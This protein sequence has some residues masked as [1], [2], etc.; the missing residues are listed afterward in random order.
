MMR[1][2][3]QLLVA[4]R[5]ERASQRREHRQLVVRPLDRGQRGA[6]G[7]DFLALVKRSA[8]DEHVRDAARLERLDVGARD[9][10]LPAHETA[11]QKADVL[12]RDLDRPPPLR[13]V[14]VQPLWLMIQSMNAP[15]A[16]GSDCSMARPVT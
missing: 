13:S 5:E 4:N 10:G 1:P 15:T 16:S 7:F 3:E 6:D 8:A 2:L 11:E 9:V 12:R 14:T